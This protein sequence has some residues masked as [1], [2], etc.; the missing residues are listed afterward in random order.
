MSA[1]IIPFLKTLQQ[2]PIAHDGEPQSCFSDHLPA[3]H[4]PSTGFIALQANAS[5]GPLNLL[6]PLPEMKRF[7]FFFFL[8]ALCIAGS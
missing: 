1:H 7:S 4:T 2:I 6:F 5:S 8:A 3:H